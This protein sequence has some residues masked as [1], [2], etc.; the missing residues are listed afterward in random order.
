MSTMEDTMP[1][2][3]EHEGNEEGVEAGLEAAPDVTPILTGNPALTVI[4]E[5]LAGSRNIVDSG[6]LMAFIDNDLFDK[7]ELREVIYEFRHHHRG[8]AFNQFVPYLLV[9][10]LC[11]DMRNI[12]T[13]VPATE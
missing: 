12:L 2:D 8:P 6:E 1:P 13:S 4:N 3:P 11:L 10:D 9:L 7:D 5:M